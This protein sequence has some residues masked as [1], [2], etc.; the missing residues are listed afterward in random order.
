MFS[1]LSKSGQHCLI[2]GPSGFEDR[3]DL[4]LGV[5]RLAPP[6]RYPDHDHPPEETYLVVTEGE[7]RQ[8]DG[9]WF[10]PGIGGLFYNVPMIKHDMRSGEAPL[11][12]FWG[13]WMNR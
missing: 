10:S 6:V 5:S 9:D 7:F 13:L 11:L 3:A 8:E 12:A 4:A 1:D 2:V